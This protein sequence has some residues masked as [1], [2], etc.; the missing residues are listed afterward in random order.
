MTMNKI[1]TISEYEETLS[2]SNAKHLIEQ[3]IDYF[4]KEI[5][6]LEELIVRAKKEIEQVSLKAKHTRAT[7]PNGEIRNVT[8]IGVEE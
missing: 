8:E 5:K 1:M 3:D 7:T 2:G 6:Q 4:E